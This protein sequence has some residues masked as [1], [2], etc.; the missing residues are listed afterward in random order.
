LLQG[1]SKLTVRFACASIKSHLSV[2]SSQRDTER[3]SNEVPE[4]ESTAQVQDSKNGLSQWNGSSRL[5]WI[6]LQL[7]QL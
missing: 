3:R 1:L 5:L 7:W 2:C 6:E 4:K